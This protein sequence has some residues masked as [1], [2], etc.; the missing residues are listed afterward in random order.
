MKDYY[1]IL[2]ISPE[3][4]VDEIKQAY[5]RLA[6]LYHPDV[7]KQPDAHE[8]FI[9]ISEAYEVLIHQTAYTVNSPEHTDVPS[10]DY[11]YETFIRKV[12]EAAQ[13]Q[14]RMR[15]EKFAREHE[16]FRQS[17]LYDASILL[18]YLGK[19]I[20]PFFAVGL[21]S[22]P[23]IVAYN[24]KSFSPILYLF[25]CWVIGIS[26]IIYIIADRKNYFKR[27]K[28]YYSFRKLKEFYIYSNPSAKEKCF[29]C[30]GL[31]AD[32]FP[33]KIEMVKVKEV[34]L[35]N[36]G[37]L[38]HYARYNRREFQV[39]Y[40]RSR[41]AFRIHSISTTIKILSI[42][43][44]MVLLPFDSLLW[45]FIGGAG[46]GW[47]INML[48]LLFSGTRSK[49]GYLFSYGMLIKIIVWLLVFIAI[50]DFYLHPLNIVTS[51]FVQFSVVILAFMDSVVE[52]LLKIPFRGGL[53]KPIL[54]YYSKITKHVEEKSS[55]YLEV[56][57][58]TAI[59]PMFR[60]IF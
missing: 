10:P 6:K 42:L 19:V 51:E 39:Y 36:S 16:A 41:K 30:P 40:P 4:T 12:R 58:W 3:S 46:I 17:G 20:L 29:Y 28:F 34:Q 53:F 9:E 35:Q 14:A 55:F 23:F 38:Q 32:S 50:S 45:R 5:R 2:E 22:I 43:V 13:K 60:W 56:P 7:N 52:Q 31:M 21:I 54:P 49:S 57:L 44:S 18:A 25:F 48:F 11:D 15:Y 27:E 59:N 47:F 24:E 33:F 8:K 37:P 1:Q 26:L